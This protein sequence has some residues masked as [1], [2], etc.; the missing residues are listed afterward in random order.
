MRQREQA[1]DINTYYKFNA[2]TAQK[3]VKDEEH[4][5]ENY[6]K[7]TNFVGPNITNKELQLNLK[8]GPISFKPPEYE[9][10]SK[11]YYNNKD[12][13]IKFHEKAKIVNIDVGD[14][15]ESKVSVDFTTLLAMFD[16][17]DEI[18]EV[19]RE[20]LLGIDLEQMGSLKDK[21][22]RL[23]DHLSSFENNEDVVQML[24]KKIDEIKNLEED[25]D[26]I[27]FNISKV[28]KII[29]GPEETKFI[30][31]KEN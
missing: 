24:Q 4:R 16:S 26:N 10:I 5:E 23:I 22:G 8:D 7:L 31:K 12:K 13:P 1:F 20:K 6:T 18:N 19:D 21:A 11:K 28:D 15:K 30:F 17:D 9:N 27:V 14:I 29:Y 3:A 2:I 25:I